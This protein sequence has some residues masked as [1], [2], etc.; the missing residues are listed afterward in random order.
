M[1]K[2][3]VLLI[4]ILLTAC[5]QQAISTLDEQ[6]DSDALKQFATDRC[7][8]ET[9]EIPNFF[10]SFDPADVPQTALGRLE[11]IKEYCDFLTETL[12]HNGIDP[13]AL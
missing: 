5:E 11:F 3:C 2:L 13:N 12:I 8:A 7:V 1:K 10:N 9:T 4:C 6:Q